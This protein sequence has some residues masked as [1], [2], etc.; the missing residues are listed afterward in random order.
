MNEVIVLN[1]GQSLHGRTG[2]YDTDSGLIK[3]WVGWI[4]AAREPTARAVD[5]MHPAK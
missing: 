2:H 1:D 5:C 3:R 4:N